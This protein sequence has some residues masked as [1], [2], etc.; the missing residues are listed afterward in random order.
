MSKERACNPWVIE[1]WNIS[2]LFVSVWFNFRVVRRFSSLS[3]LSFCLVS[4]PSLTSAAALRPLATHN[5]QWIDLIYVEKLITN[6]PHNSF[7]QLID[8]KMWNVQTN[9]KPQS[10]SVKCVNSKFS[11]YGNQMTRYIY[12]SKLL[13]VMLMFSMYCHNC[14]HQHTHKWVIG[15]WNDDLKQ[16]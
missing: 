5:T 4:C 1:Y 9:A 2:R 14:T 7:A 8:E 6:P 12:S 15:C 13:R 10:N 11:L 3:P 16:K